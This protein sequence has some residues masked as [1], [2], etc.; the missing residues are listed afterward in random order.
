MALE[1]SIE[2]TDQD[3][4]NRCAANPP[5]TD[6]ASGPAWNGWGV[7][8]SNARFQTAKNAGLTAAQVP[9]LKLKWA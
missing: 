6:P 2:I 8:M 5:M 1:F 7:D 3:L 4:P 9:N